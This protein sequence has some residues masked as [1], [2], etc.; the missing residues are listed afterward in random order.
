[1]RRALARDRGLAWP[2]PWQPAGSRITQP[3]VAPPAADPNAHPLSD[4]AGSDALRRRADEIESAFAALPPALRSLA[5]RQFD[6]GFA[7]RAAAELRERLDLDL[8]AAWFDARWNAPLDMRVLHARCVLRIFAG[9]VARA[10]DRS[11]ALTSEGEPVEAL[12][13]RWGFHAVDISPCADGRLAGVVDYILRVP[14]A[15]VSHR[16]SYA[17]AMFDVEQALARWGAIELR[18]WRES[19]PNPASD[20][21]RYLKVGVYHF[22]SS[23]PARE[24]CAAHAGDEAR[25]ARLLLQRL[26]EF[27]QAVARAH[28]CGARVATLL[29]GVDTDTDAIRVHVPDAAGAMAVDRYVCSARLYEATRSL[30]REAAKEAIRQAV[31]ACAG[32]PA[33][34]AATEG[35]R[36]FCGYLLKNNLAQVDAVRTRHGGAY[37]E[38]GHDE[39]LILVGDPLDEVQLR[40][41]AFQAQMESIE[42]G[43]G[44]LDVGVRILGARH[45]EQGVAVPVLV[46][47]RYDARIPGARERARVRALR[48]AAAA[49]ERHA[50][51][52]AASELWVEAAVRAEGAASLEFVA[53]AAAQAQG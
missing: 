28:G 50:A 49:R 41:L 12:I 39:R 24:G 48:M 36:W 3:N 11:H 23:D 22:S 7:E 35:M 38:R 32:V 9:L 15:V 43:A 17:G 25:A 40:N 52:V 14:P 8:P 44:D 13:R 29:V 30:A 2:T 27:S 1:M 51:A 46:L 42:E 20:P 16:R 53:A 21:T 34:D 37:P 18:R 10:F 33:G 19:R 31:A 6:P 26:E 4:G 45:R 47:Q 5:A